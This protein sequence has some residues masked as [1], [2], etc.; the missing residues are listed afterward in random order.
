MD[1][2]CAPGNSQIVLNPEPERR[3]RLILKVSA[4]FSED[5]AAR[6]QFN[7]RIEWPEPLRSDTEILLH[8]TLR[9]ETTVETG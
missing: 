1:G 4:S 5:Q 9:M 2:C 3:R 8:Q 7:I 6:T